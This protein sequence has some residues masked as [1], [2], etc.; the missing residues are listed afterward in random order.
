MKN[1]QSKYTDTH[2]Y[3]KNT[4]NK[5][6]YFSSNIILINRTSAPRTLTGPQGDIGIPGGAETETVGK[7]KWQTQALPANNS[8][9]WLGPQQTGRCL[10]VEGPLGKGLEKRAGIKNRMANPQ[11][12]QSVVCP[13][14][15]GR[16]HARSNG[17]PR[18]YSSQPPPYNGISRGLHLSLIKEQDHSYRVA[19]SLGAGLSAHTHPV[20]QTLLCSQE[21]ALS[22]HD[23]LICDIQLCLVCQPP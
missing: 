8:C 22:S 7:E 15:C 17:G 19:A 14:P 2:K 21:G 11:S 9:C 4:T 13:I 5:K 6:K 16:L 12:P 1:Y 20:A 18:A 3:T 10:A 23:C